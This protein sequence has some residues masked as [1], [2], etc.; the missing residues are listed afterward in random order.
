MSLNVSL[1][2]NNLKNTY[3]FNFN[4]EGFKI[5]TF[6]ISLSSSGLTES[7]S[8]FLSQ[9]LVNNSYS[10][11]Y[12]F[13]SP[14]FKDSLCNS[15]YYEEKV[16]LFSSY[17]WNFVPS[18]NDHV[19]LL[20]Y[21]FYNN[22]YLLTV[23]LSIS[24]FSQNI[25]AGVF[26][27]IERSLPSNSLYLGN[28]SL[29]HFYRI[30]AAILALFYVIT[31]SIFDWLLHRIYIRRTI[32]LTI[33]S[34]L[35]CGLLYFFNILAGIFFTNALWFLVYPSFNDLHG[36][37]IGSPL[38]CLF[39]GLWYFFRRSGKISDLDIL[40]SI[41]R[42][43]IETMAF[44]AIC[45]STY[46]SWDLLL[47]VISISIYYPI[48]VSL[49]FIIHY[50]SGYYIIGLELMEES[51]YLY[52]PLYWIWW[53]TAIFNTNALVGLFTL[54]VPYENNISYWV[55][56]ILLTCI[57]VILNYPCY[58]L[59]GVLDLLSNV[60]H[61]IELTEVTNNYTS[62]RTDLGI[63]DRIINFI[64]TNSHV[65]VLRLYICI[66][67]Y[68]FSGGLLWSMVISYFV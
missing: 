32:N 25:G 42:C 43:L 65:I 56:S 36:F 49:G 14:I 12:K 64:T 44:I 8:N 52:G 66:F 26:A 2:S 11:I 45:A 5:P 18:F 50:I 9:L 19:N 17:L 35:M 39:S 21:T 7:I 16:R 29:Y 31:G 20:P 28:L 57:S 37:I 54:N 13:S 1:F 33:Y 10:T 60:P 51:L 3:V 40:N 59:N 4:T 58:Y 38:S 55:I 24:Y 6:D 22:L 23:L 27:F 67:S 15:I 68:C 30:I 46:G 41:F 47:E 61:D 63:I 53:T 48:S 62:V 34:Y